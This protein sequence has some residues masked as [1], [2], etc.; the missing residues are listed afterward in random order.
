MT[1][2]NDDNTKNVKQVQEKKKIKLS[3]DVPI[4]KFI[5]KTS[6]EEKA[7]IDYKVACCIYA[8]NYPFQTVERFCF[9][10][11]CKAMLPGYV[12]PN[13]K[14]LATTLLDQAYND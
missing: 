8:C 14:I 9:I 1:T 13:R 4:T 7:R 12:L 3:N 11:M 5:V 10:E 6:K 2:K